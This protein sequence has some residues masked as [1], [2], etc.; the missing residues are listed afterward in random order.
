MHIKISKKEEREGGGKE[1][2]K[3]AKPYYSIFS[4]EHT[5]SSRSKAIEYG[6]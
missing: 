4:I 5:G 6:C 3:Q 2:R 1:E